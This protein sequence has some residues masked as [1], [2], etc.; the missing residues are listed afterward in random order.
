MATQYFKRN[1]SLNLY[2]EGKKILLVCFLLPLKRDKS[3][4]HL[5]PIS[6]IWRPLAFLPVT[7]SPCAP[8]W[9]LDPDHGPY[10]QG[11]PLRQPA[12]GTP[13]PAQLWPHLVG[14]SEWAEIL[15]GKLASWRK[16]GWNWSL[17][18]ACWGGVLSKVTAAIY[19]LLTGSGDRK[20]LG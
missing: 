18:I 15:A 20:L 13:K 3:A 10:P 6:S 4:W 2:R 9:A 5:K 16:W 17:S 12:W 11:A 7:L 19:E 1:L 8:G 14:S